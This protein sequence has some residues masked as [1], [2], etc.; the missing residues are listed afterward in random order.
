M[1]KKMNRRLR[2]MWMCGLIFLL[3]PVLVAQAR[4]T[5]PPGESPDI[6]DYRYLLSPEPILESGYYN[7]YEIESFLCA[8][9]L[10]FIR[11]EETYKSTR[12]DFLVNPASLGEKQVTE[13]RKQLIGKWFEERVTV[14]AVGDVT[15]YDLDIIQTFYKTVNRLIGQER[16]VFVPDCQVANIIIQLEKPDPDYRLRKYIGESA[17]LQDNLRVRLSV[18]NDH[19]RLD[20]YKSGSGRLINKSSYI[21]LTPAELEFRKENRLV[22]VFIRKV[23]NH[24]VMYFAIIHEL[25]HTIGF[26][27]HSPY[28]QSHLFPLPVQAYPWKRSAPFLAP[29]AERMI[30]MLYRP[31]I[32]PGMTIAEAGEILAR[33]K[34][35]GKTPKNN[36]IHFLH[37]QK[38]NIFAQK[39]ALMARAKAIYNNRMDLYIQLDTWTVKERGFLE[40]MEEIRNDKKKSSQVVRDIENCS[41]LLCKLTRI[42]RELILD[43]N[44]KKRLLAKIANR[45]MTRAE[46]QQIKD[47]DEEIAVLRDLLYTAQKISQCEQEIE[48]TRVFTETA[49]IE[50]ELQVVLRKLLYIDHELANLEAS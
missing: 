3:F 2:T 4:S 5:I 23:D 1:L 32:I 21:T 25:M 47:L 16:F 35:L 46:K 14:T 41:F 34:R 28:Y 9:A 22:K 11:A 31:E 49:D 33:L 37:E 30:E 44:Q 26:P 29:I 43:E 38:K 19:I 18:D 8:N 15:E 13:A 7:R 45:K 20:T 12:G 24:V 10:S 42:R 17:V 6:V 36:T 39:E 50:Q 40:E 48:R 27:G